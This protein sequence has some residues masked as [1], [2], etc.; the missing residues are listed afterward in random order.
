[1]EKNENV[2][3]R[4][5][6][7]KEI[8]FEGIL[9]IAKA[10]YGFVD[11]TKKNGVFVSPHNMMGAFSGDTVKAKL[12]KSRNLEECEI[13]EILKR[14]IVILTGVYVEEKNKRYVKPYNS[15]LSVE[16]KVKREHTNGAKNG[17]LVVCDIL[18]YG[19]EQKLPSVYIKEILGDINKKG[20]D[21]T[22]VLRKYGIMETF[23]DEVLE[24]QIDSNINELELSTREDYTNEMIVTIDGDDAKDLDDAVS[25]VKSGNHYILGVHI[26]DVSHYVH[27]KSP[28][29]MEAY[30][31]G[32]SVYLPDRV[33]PMLPFTLSNNL[34][35]LN[36]NEI[37]LTMSCIMTIDKSGEIVDYK[38]K[39]SYIKTK[40]RLTY[41]NVKKM[42]SGDRIESLE[43][44]RPTLQ[45]MHELYNILRAKRKEDGFIEFNFPESKFTLDE[46]GKAIDVFPYEVSFANEMIEEFMLAANVSAANFSLDNGL[47]FVYRVHGQPKIEKIEGL[48]KALNI[49]GISFKPNPK[50]TPKEL[51][52]II[53]KAENTEVKTIVHQL[54]LRSMQKAVYSET[55]SLHY[56]LNFPRYCHF[57]SP[58]RRYPDLVIHRIISDFLEGKPIRKYKKF[59]ADASLQS[60][61]TEVNAFMAERDCDDIKKAEYMSDKIGQSFSG[62]IVGMTETGFFVGLPNTVEG[63]VPLSSI[64]EDYFEYR[65]DLFIMQGRKSNYKIGQAVEV[66]LAKTNVTE[67]KIEFEIAN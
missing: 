23:P 62:N 37:K 1:M 29:D 54:A 28:I 45:T 34:C 32:T 17:D 13:V 31:R 8:Y 2:K 26:A 19:T 12:I 63:F 10:G 57:T 50:P 48:Y 64:T 56:G 16:F 9:S 61:E 25:V 44:L 4:M 11:T 60:S 27:A 15:K 55:V 51:D 35:S 41:T 22:V 66:K 14:G 42:L 7:K 24:Q 46:T 58:I 39:K 47:P 38:V 20:N 36:P 67:G 40:E 65:S 5:K 59:V 3:K 21:I 49:F 18:S 33:A 43:Y 30:Y 52:A 53:K 6:N